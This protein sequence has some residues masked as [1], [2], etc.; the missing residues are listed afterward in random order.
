MQ[1]VLVQARD[2]ARRNRLEMSRLTMIVE[3]DSAT[4]RCL[5]GIFSLQGWEVCLAP[6]VSEALTLL[7]HG[8]VADFLILDLT[9]PDGGGEAV[10]KAVKDA[11]LKSQVIVCTGTMDPIR[12]LR[13]R[14]LEP[15]ITL[16]KPVDPDVICRL[17]ESWAA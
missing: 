2:L 10:L 3:D 17:C 11:G 4:R 13:L 6:T 9:L 14:E 12:L 15:D 7:E 5:G 1:A 8:L 16:I